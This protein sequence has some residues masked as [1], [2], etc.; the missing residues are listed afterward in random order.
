MPAAWLILDS[1]RRR[2]GLAKDFGAD[3][4][5]SAAGD[6]DKGYVNSVQQA[7]AAAE[8]TVTDIGHITVVQGTGGFSDTRSAVLFATMIAWQQEG[9]KLSE[10]VEE[11]G[12]PV[13]AIETGAQYGKLAK[14]VKELKPRYFAEPNI[15]QSKK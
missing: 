5:W 10:I 2:I 8:Y 6:R 4:V 1:N 14:V 13:Q 3:V 12:Q 11:P 9:T 7:I 15:T